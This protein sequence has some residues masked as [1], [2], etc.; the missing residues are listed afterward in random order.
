[1]TAHGRPDGFP[2]PAPARC[3]DSQILSDESLKLVLGQAF[4]STPPDS[5]YRLYAVFRNETESLSTIVCIH[6]DASVSQFDNEVFEGKDEC[7]L[8]VT[9]LGCSSVVGLGMIEES[10]AATPELRPFLR[11]IARHHGLSEQAVVHMMRSDQP[12]HPNHGIESW[13]IAKDLL[14]ATRMH[15]LP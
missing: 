7:E 15:L 13:G 10:H 1:M 3:V 11:S 9:H 12:F 4:D 14:L 8:D 6:T 2:A 5:G